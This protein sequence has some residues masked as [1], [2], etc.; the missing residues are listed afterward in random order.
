MFGLKLLSL[1][2]LVPGSGTIASNFLQQQKQFGGGGGVDN[3]NK[4]V[5][6]DCF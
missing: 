2:K 3:N 4:L 6:F 5:L 1:A